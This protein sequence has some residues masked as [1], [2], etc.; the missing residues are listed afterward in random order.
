[1]CKLVFKCFYETQTC[2]DYYENIGFIS[3]SADYYNNLD[4]VIG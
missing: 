2:L 1:M 3:Q 4:V